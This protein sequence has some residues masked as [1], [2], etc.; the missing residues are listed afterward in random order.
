M[1]C[2]TSDLFS[3]KSARDLLLSGH[4]LGL[5]SRQPPIL[6]QFSNFMGENVHREKVGADLNLREERVQ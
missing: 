3:E 6:A 2:R 4:P 1:Q 5:A